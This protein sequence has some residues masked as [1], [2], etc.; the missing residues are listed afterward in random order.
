M[1]GSR[2]TKPCEDFLVQ[3]IKNDV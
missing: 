3:E 2:V 1:K